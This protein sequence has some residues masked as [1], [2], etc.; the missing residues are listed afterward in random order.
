M[1]S[2]DNLTFASEDQRTLAQFG[3]AAL[4]Y[5]LEGTTGSHRGERRHVLVGSPQ[6]AEERPS[7]FLSSF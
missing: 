1:A 4:D 3:A 7:Q 6:L 2:L 5:D